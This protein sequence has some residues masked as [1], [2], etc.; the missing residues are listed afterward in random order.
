MLRP[1]RAGLHHG[2]VGEG[3]GAGRRGQALHARDGGDPEGA[4]DQLREGQRPRGGPR[5]AGERGLRHPEGEPPADDAGHRPGDRR[6][7]PVRPGGRLPGEHGARRGVL[8]QHGRDAAHQRLRRHPDGHRA[9]RGDLGHERGGGQGRGAGQAEGGAQGRGGARAA[10]GAVPQRLP[11]GDRV[12]EPALCR[13]STPLRGR[14]PLGELGCHLRVLRVELLRELQ[15]LQQDRRPHRRERARGRRV[16]YSHLPPG[17]RAAG[18]VLRVG[19]A[20]RAVHDRVCA[21]DED[22]ACL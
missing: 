10:G 8:L 6:G 7:R 17:T 13:Q 12:G 18:P 11:G 16:Q 1:V 4:R 14:G 20:P 9:G 21:H 5:L 2:P 22:R 19:C 3:P 15:H